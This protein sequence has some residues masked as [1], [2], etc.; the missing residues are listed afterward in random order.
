VKALEWSSAIVAVQGRYHDLCMKRGAIKQACLQGFRRALLFEHLQKGFTALQM[1][2]SPQR[3]GCHPGL[4]QLHSLAAFSLLDP[5]L[6]VGSLRR[7]LGS[8]RMKHPEQ[9]ELLS[10]QGFLYRSRETSTIS[11]YRHSQ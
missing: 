7:R 11:P 1:I 4:R 3:I 10:L 9:N 6:G 8:P 5:I 2:F